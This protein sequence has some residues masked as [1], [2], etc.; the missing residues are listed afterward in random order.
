MSTKISELEN[1]T[2][3][4]YDALIETANN[5]RSC[6]QYK[7]EFV[8]HL[9]YDYLFD[10]NAISRDITVQEMAQR[11]GGLRAYRRGSAF[12][13]EHLDLIVKIASKIYDDSRIE[14]IGYSGEPENVID[15]SQDYLSDFYDIYNEYLKY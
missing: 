4:H 7:Q 15:L 11:L 13:L 5:F 8:K 2:Q 6:D 3:K 9:L 1:I 14:I 10:T 12:D